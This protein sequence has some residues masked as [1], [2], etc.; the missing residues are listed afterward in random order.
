MIRLMPQDAK[1]TMPKIFNVNFGENKK[2]LDSAEMKEYIEAIGSK[3][4]DVE[5][6]G[7]QQSYQ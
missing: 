7:F 1:T 6:K 2:F 4:D 5:F 3:M